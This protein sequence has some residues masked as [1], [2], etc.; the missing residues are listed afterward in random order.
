MRLWI[1]SE[2][3]NQ[4]GVSSHLCE[5]NYSIGTSAESFFL[6]KMSGFGCINILDIHVIMSLYTSNKNISIF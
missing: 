2:V 5:K 6:I 3:V 4:V 1:Y